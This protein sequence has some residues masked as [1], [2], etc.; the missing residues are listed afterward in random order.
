MRGT[1]VPMG[2]HEWP[3]WVPARKKKIGYQWVPGTWKIENCG[4]RW[5]PGTWQK[6]IFGYRFVNKSVCKLDY[7]ISYVSHI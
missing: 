3:L 7:L 1:L 5:V 4:Y 6:K 2:S